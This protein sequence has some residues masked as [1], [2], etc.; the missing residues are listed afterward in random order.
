MKAST[1]N[2]SAVSAA[3]SPSVRAAA[4]SLSA[5]VPAALSALLLTLAGCA[6]A[7]PP[8]ASS[9]ARAGSAS[10]V[11]AAAAPTVPAAPKQQAFPQEAFR[12][13]QPAAAVP[14][15]FQLPAVQ[16]F[17]LKNGIEVYLVEKHDLP[18]I[19]GSLSFDAGEIND[20]SNKI[21]LASVC[22]DMM[23]EGTK[24]LDRMAFNEALADIASDVSSHARSDTQEVS[25]RTLSKHLDR[26][27]ELFA[28]TVRNPGMRK[29]DFDRVVR[30][31]LERLKQEKGSATSVARR[32][33]D[34]VLYGA[35]HPL[36]RIVTDKTLKRLRVGDCKRYH[37]STV[38]PRGATLFVVGDMTQGQVRAKFD[39]GLAGWN[40][41]PKGRASARTPK[42]R[43]SKLYF[44]NVAG[45]AQSAIRIMHFGPTRNA[46]DYFANSMMSSVLG[47]GFSGRV[48]MNLREDKGYSYGAF[49]TFQY[50]RNHGTFVAGSSVR[51]DATYQS[52]IELMDEI[53]GLQSAGKPITQAELTREQ[54]GAILGL[55]ARFATAPQALWMYREL[56]YFGLPLDYWNNYV[57]HVREVTLEQAAASASAHLRPEAALVLV[58]GD[59]KAPMIQ[60]NQDGKDVPLLDAAG[61][62]VTLLA[63][64][65]ELARSVP[66]GAGKVTTLDADGRILAK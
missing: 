45:S 53:K 28:D 49:G 33:A 30:Q 7:A 3:F 55:P 51:S 63:S 26:T 61:K 8:P 38:R 66:I 10:A 19:S 18:I 64:L 16:N 2:P 29:V 43:G 65:K 5:P 27:F 9:A 37:R 48:N 59:A 6:G 34:H 54:N 41:K 57:G 39:T 58:V 25:F 11:Q 31:R 21:G 44:V 17:Q 12:R 56:V 20:P 62:P 1:S 15:P 24:K 13:S 46:R 23:S 40:G 22:M 14:R 60:R 4:F 50:K 35:R 36:G 32:L 42:S 47:G 52:V